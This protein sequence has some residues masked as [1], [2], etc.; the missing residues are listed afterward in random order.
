VTLEFRA[1]GREFRVFR[2]LD[3]RAAT[4]RLETRQLG[5]WQPV[6]GKAREIEE[7]VERIV[8]LDFDG[9][10]KAVILPQGEFDEFLR[11]DRATR[12]R[13]LTGLLSLDL[14]DQMKQRANDQ[15]RDLAREAEWKAGLIQPEASPE[16]R[17]GLEADLAKLELEAARLS[18]RLQAVQ[19]S[20]PLAAELRQRRRALEESESELFKRKRELAAVTSRLQAP[21]QP[22]VPE[23]E[24][25]RRELS[26]AEHMR[27]HLKL[28]S[29]CPVCLQLVRQLPK[30]TA[31]ERR[32]RN[33]REKQEQERAQCEMQH[34][35]LERQI[36][37]AETAAAALRA[38][39]DSHL[40]KWTRA[41]AAL[42][43]PPARDE[44]A[45]LDMAQSAVNA[46]LERTR[47]RLAGQQTALQTLDDR[48]KENK[49]L[50]EQSRRLERKSAL[51]RQLGTL[52]NAANFQQ[53]LLAESVQR[54][55]RAAS[56]HFLTLSGGRYSFQATGDDFE[57]L[58]QWNAGE[59]RSVST[60]SGGE[61]FVASLSLALALAA[62]I[63]DLGSERGVAALES[64]FLDEGFSTL[65]AESLAK[66]V[67]T[68]QLLENGERLIGVVTHLPALAEQ[69]PARIDVEKSI[70][71]SR[72]S[73]N[74]LTAPQGRST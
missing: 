37:A 74:A 23:P 36:E 18:E 62:S 66:S 41:T 15:A 51:Y 55:A 53:F 56:V 52:L 14:Y 59:P 34:Q 65:D 38:Q 68:L 16:A 61:S 46:L 67:D 32:L 44:A 42:D 27:L 4:V 60:L 49:K 22:T 63:S 57:V 31:P 17:A 43:L 50:R 25:E 19:K 29:R 33:H 71:G 12:R 64:L 5:E 26:P 54:L 13:I 39:T 30:E 70:T 11:G 73:Y 45:A 1:A 7:E 69:L 6:T 72:L 28:G 9:F 47:I 8:G 2:S 3:D 48:I 24:P 58:D 35:L 40:K 10:T 21:A 20:F